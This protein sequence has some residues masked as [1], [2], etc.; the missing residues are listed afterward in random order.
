MKNKNSSI[1]REMEDALRQCLS[2]CPVTGK[3]IWI[4]TIHSHAVFASEAG[5]ISKKGYRVIQFQKKLFRG[6]RLAV[7]FMTGKWPTGVVDHKN[8]NKSDDSW[9]NLRDVN[10][11]QNMR[12]QHVPHKRNSS[13][14]IGVSYHKVTGKW[15][16]QLN[17]KDVKKKHIGSFNTPEEAAVAYHNAK[18]EYERRNS[19][20]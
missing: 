2:Y 1:S 13:G 11:S 17:Y 20:A 6:N 7:F 8:G 15:V 3:F 4:K 9:N 14:F 5:T 18:A 19:I 12:N 10:Q 16:A